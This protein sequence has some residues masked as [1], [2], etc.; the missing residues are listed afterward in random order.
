MD[1][2]YLIKM[3]PI[4]AFLLA[5]LSGCPTPVWVSKEPPVPLEQFLSSKW[6]DSVDEV[7]RAIKRDGNQWFK[8][9]TDQ[10]PYSLYVSGNYLDY[11]VIFS[12]FFTPKSKKLYRVDVTCSD[13]KAYERVKNILVQKYRNPFYSQPDIDYWS[14]DDKSLVVLQ[15]NTNQ[16]QI[17]YSSGPFLIQ[18][19]NEGGLL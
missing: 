1:F 6:G 8:E 9:I 11:P 7:K 10:A 2:R 3:I 15:K 17:S 16:V 4:F 13:L 19:Q 12:Y 18:N 5:I 14:W